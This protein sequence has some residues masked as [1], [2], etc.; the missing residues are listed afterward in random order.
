MVSFACVKPCA[1][2]NTASLHLRATLRMLMIKSNPNELQAARIDRL[3][4]A[5][6]HK[7]FDLSRTTPLERR[8]ADRLP[9]LNCVR[10][11]SPMAVTCVVRAPLAIYFLCA[12]CG[13]HW[14][15]MKPGIVLS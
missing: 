6:K 2:V 12:S 7:P 9:I 3:I 11:A 13:D 5:L 14:S 8:H 4:K 1:V 10:C 15:V